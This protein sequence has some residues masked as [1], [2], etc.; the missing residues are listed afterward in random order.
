MLIISVDGNIGAGKSTLLNVM[1]KEDIIS[2]TEPIDDWIPLLSKIEENPAKYVYIMQLAVLK[3]YILIKKRIT[4]NKMKWK[5]KIIIIERS[6]DTSLSVF[7]KIYAKEQM[8]TEHQYNQLYKLS[9]EARIKFDLRVLI[10]LSERQC[11]QRIRSRGRE[12]EKSIKIDY[13]KKIA[14]QQ[15]AMYQ[16]FGK[17]GQKILHIDGKLSKC[18]I[19]LI[20]INFLDKLS[21]MNIK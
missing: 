11:M 15:A 17:L 6:I 8:L 12:C 5:N 18:D 10:S 2:I 1:R 19:K 13:L 21:K 20:F 14:I 7:A 9:D 3:H 4:E 16:M